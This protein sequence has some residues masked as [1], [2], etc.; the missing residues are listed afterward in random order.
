MQYLHRPPK[1]PLDSGGST[2]R[3]NSER[4]RAV[5]PHFVRIPEQMMNSTPSRLAIAKLWL[6]KAAQ[7]VR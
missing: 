2:P 4:K 7:H 6:G 3:S 5:C 1:Q